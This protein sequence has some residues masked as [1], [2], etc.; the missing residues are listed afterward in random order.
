MMSTMLKLLVVIGLLVMVIVPTMAQDTAEWDV[1]LYDD[2]QILVVTAD[3][4]S[5]SIAL[6]EAAQN[7]Q[8][9][10][11]PYNMALSPNRQYF[12]FVTEVSSSTAIDATLHIADLDN[13][14]CCIEVE[15][16]LAQ[17]EV[18]NLGVFSPDGTQV[19]VTFLNAYYRESESV[20][21][22]LDIATGEIVTTLD[23]WAALNAPAVFPLWWDENGI[24]FI[25]TCY[26]CGAGP[27]GAYQVWNPVTGD[28]IPNAGEIA[29]FGDTLP[30][31]GEIV[32]AAQD[33]DYPTATDVDVMV[34]PF[35]VIEYVSGEGADATIGYYNPQNLNLMSP[36]WVIDGHAYLIDDQFA[37]SGTLVYR[38]GTTEALTYDDTQLFIVGTPD[39]WLAQRY[40]TGELLYYQLRGGELVTHNLGQH[41]QTI[42][43]LAAPELGH[44]IENPLTPI[45]GS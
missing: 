40:A 10:N 29:G 18:I 30:V 31:T 35:N 6:P 14:T 39:G 23:P 45:I 27:I 36:R 15:S 8:R 43:V 25:P 2:A 24:S 28:I 20:I 32:R 16:P 4:M 17:P 38:D 3:G 42:T 9:G 12:A 26:P 21:A 19:M 5:D 13:Q 1:L 41:D 44:S 37:Q 11:S 33:T 7:I 22:I 34:G